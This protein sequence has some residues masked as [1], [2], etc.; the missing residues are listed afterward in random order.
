MITNEVLASSSYL[1]SST[2][3]LWLLELLAPQQQSPIP[4]KAERNAVEVA[5]KAGGQ[6]DT[7]PT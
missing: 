4:S 3:Q 6:T 2:Q 7:I 5:A 1:S